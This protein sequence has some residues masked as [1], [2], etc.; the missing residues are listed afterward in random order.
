MIKYLN[1]SKLSKNKYIVILFRFLSII[2]LSSITTY[3]LLFGNI[4]EFVIVYDNISIYGILTIVALTFFKPLFDTLRWYVVFKIYHKSKFINLHQATII[5]YS[6]NA[7]GITT[8]GVGFKACLMKKI[9]N[10]RNSFIILIIE[11][12]ISAIIKFSIFVV[13]LL[14]FSKKY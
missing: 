4:E 14:V 12:L 1:F 13:A 9:T 7:T 5:G 3:V 10:F 8:V 11:R 6:I 2:I